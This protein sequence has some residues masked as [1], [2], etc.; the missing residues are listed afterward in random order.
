MTTSIE[1]SEAVDTDILRGAREIADFLCGLGLEG[2]TETDVY[3]L[4]RAQKVTIGRLGKELLASKKQ[5]SRDLQRA[6]K[7][8][9]A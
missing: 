4:S 6:A 5:L 3:Y 9:P 1:N 7:A 2:T 8:Q